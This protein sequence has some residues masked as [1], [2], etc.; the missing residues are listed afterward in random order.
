MLLLLTDG[1]FR[2]LWA[3]GVLAIFGHLIYGMVH[4][5]LTLAVTD[6]PFWVGASS[7]SFG[8]GLLAFGVLG[9]LVADRFPR[10]LAAAASELAMTLRSVVLAWLILY[11]QVELWHLMAASF[12]TGLSEAVRIPSMF[13]LNIDVVGKQRLLSATAA[14]FAAFGAAGIM[15]PLATGALVARWDLGWAYAAMAVFHLLSAVVM[16][17]LEAPPSAGRSEA[18]ASRL[19]PWRSIR[20]GAVHVF[21]TPWIRT[22]L[23]MQLVGEAFGWSHITMLPVMA[24]DVLGVDAQG[25]GYLMAVSY[26]GFLVG[27]LG[28]SA[29][30]DLRHKSRA[31]VAGY[32]GYGLLLILF[33]TS[34]SFPLSLALLGAAYAVESL[35]EAN[36]H[37]MV[38]A[39]VPDRMRG[40]VI[41]FQ[42][43]TWGVT[44]FSGFYTGAA[45][46]RFG[47]P[48]AIAVGGAVVLANAVRL[49]PALALSAPR[50]D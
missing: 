11:G 32:G 27:N 15:A 2:L 21:R 42:A 48:V 3:G 33:A 45:A 39:S 29:L 36:L 31:A 6:S 25:L 17:R 9:G 24:R 47:A 49:T 8:I 40:R 10:N 41:S 20:E 30:G 44:G 1:R 46:R 12:V 19:S 4:G 18:A 38:Q 37:T 14:N 13:S 50:Q 23:A 22:L 26:G 35:Y 34:R 5:W 7:G 16:L 28:L 43:L